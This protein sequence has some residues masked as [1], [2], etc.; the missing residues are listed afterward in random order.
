MMGTLEVSFYSASLVAIFLY[1][2]LSLRRSEFGVILVGYDIF[3]FLGCCVYPLVLEAG[4]ITPGGN[5]KAAIAFIGKPGLLTA[6]HVFAV[7]VGMLLGYLF[8]S[9]SGR[10]TA[11]SMFR[12]K[13]MADSLISDPLKAWKKATLV[14]LAVLVAHMW[15]VGLDV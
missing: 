2:F 5:G 3:F 15:L 14:G 1:F 6:T 8:G 11:K 4:W 7:S 12:Y 13:N 10:L 9:G